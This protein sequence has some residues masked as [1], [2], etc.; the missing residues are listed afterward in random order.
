MARKIRVIIADDHP[1][2]RQ[3]LRQVLDRHPRLNVVEEAEDG[4]MA[5]ELADENRTDVLVLDIRMPGMDGFD[6]VRELQSRGSNVK[7][8]FLTMHNEEDMFQEAMD[9]GVKGY[10]LKESAARDVI[11]GI[12]TVMQDRHYVSPSISEFVFNRNRQ[13]D[14]LNQEKPG[15]AQL[16]PSEKRILKLVSENLT[17]KEIASKLELSVRTIDNHRANIC[18]KLDLHGIHSLVKFAFDHRSQL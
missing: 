9:L 10:V 7:V 3:G 6:V 5:L 8:L 17:S 11:H 2:F 4:E 15:L 12:E 1:I 14:A 13:A 16:T 18:A